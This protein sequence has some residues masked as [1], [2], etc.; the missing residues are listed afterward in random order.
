MI[1]MPQNFHN[2]KVYQEAY[3]LSKDIY[4]ELKEID[5]HWRL[6]D[7]LFGSTTSICTNLAEMSSMENKNQQRQKIITCIGEANEA[8]FWLNFCRDVELI[9]AE[10]HKEYV[11]RLKKIRMMLF[12][13][14]RSIE[15]DI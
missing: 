14:K 6:K 4:N 2:L 7:Q 12:N 5:K 8:E 11:N 13:L 15:K 9:K 1:K 10:K 3:A